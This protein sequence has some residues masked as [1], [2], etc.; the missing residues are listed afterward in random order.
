[1]LPYP[2][3]LEQGVVQF[4]RGKG[5]VMSRRKGGVDVWSVPT[6]QE[7]PQLKLRMKLSSFESDVM[8]CGLSADGRLLGVSSWDGFRLYEIWDGV[9]EVGMSRTF[10]KVKGI[11]IGEHEEQRLSGAE[12]MAFCG[13][14]LVCVTRGGAGL[15][16]FEK[17][18][19]TEWSY[20]RIGSKAKS[21]GRVACGQNMVMVSDSNGEVFMATFE[22]GDDVDLKGVVWRKLLTNGRLFRKVTAMVLSPSGKMVGIATSDMKLYVQDSGGD[23]SSKC[24]SFIKLRGIATSLSFAGNEESI[25]V[26]GE[27]FCCVCGVPQLLPMKRKREEVENET[28]GN[29][30]KSRVFYLDFKHS[31]LGA[32]VTGESRLVVVRRPW[33]LLR[34][35]LPDAIVKKPFGA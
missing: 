25:L 19:L 9:G 13:E 22:E 34:S 21:L 15:A 16:V 1:M 32:C 3:G 6:S 26:S 8:S 17:G 7:R 18:V 33:L 29:G 24:G 20:G 30:Q 12:D 31:V 2:H 10:G 23:R 4:C 28:E 5:L 27:R 11:E 14:K 35:S